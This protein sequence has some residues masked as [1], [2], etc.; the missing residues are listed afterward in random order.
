M[1]L[2]NEELVTYDFKKLFRDVEKANEMNR[3]AGNNELKV[4]FCSVYGEG[5]D[6]C[7]YES[8]SSYRE[9]KKYMLEERN[10]AKEILNAEFEIGKRYNYTWSVFNYNGSFI[11]YIVK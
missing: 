4:N 8:F 7:E 2:L 5:D 1:K 3:L 11:V 6:K 9:F 10:D